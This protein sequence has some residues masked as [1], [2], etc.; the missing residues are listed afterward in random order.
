MINHI[1]RE[2]LKWSAAACVFLEPGSSVITIDLLPGINWLV[3]KVWHIISFNYCV[4]RYSFRLSPFSS[5][6]YVLFLDE[7]NQKSWPVWNLP[8]S[9]PKF[10]KNKNSLVPH[11]NSLFFSSK[12]LQSLLSAK[13][14]NGRQLTVITIIIYD[15]LIFH[16]MLNYFFNGW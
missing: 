7:K 4:F 9:F 8:K 11:S 10:R 3:S 5:I 16:S 14:Q 1:C 13:F 15:N 12:F 2:I 6:F